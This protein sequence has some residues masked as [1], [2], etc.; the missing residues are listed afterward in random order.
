MIYSMTGYAIQSQ[1]ILEDTVT[2]EVRSLNSKFFDFSLKCPDKFFYLEEQIKKSTKKLL[3]R[4]II[5]T[6]LVV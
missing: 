5:E 1:E 6:R 3:K 4:A 2:I